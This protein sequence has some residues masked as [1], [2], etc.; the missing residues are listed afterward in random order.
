MMPS[1]PLP[2][3]PSLWVLLATTVVLA[4]GC[5]DPVG[6]NPDGGLPDA[7]LPTEA[8]P[9]AENMARIHFFRMDGDYAGWA[10][11]LWGDDLNLP[12]AVT[13][14]NPWPQ[15]G[16]YLDGC[17]PWAYFDIPIKPGAAGI[18]FILHKGDTKS[19]PEDMTWSFAG[20][21]KEL[22]Q[23][24]GEATLH[25]TRPEVSCKDIGSLATARAHWVDRGR[26][27]WPLPG[28]LA[29][30]SFRLYHSATGAV[31]V[32]A[33]A[34]TISGG[35]RVDLTLTSTPWAASANGSR[36]PHLNGAPVL[37]LP[38]AAL[39]SAPAWLRGQVVVARF[40]AQ[41]ALVDH[42][43]LQV[44]GVLDDLY[45][46][47]AKDAQLGVSWV[48]GSP[49]FRVWA[50]TAQSVAL[51]LYAS[52]TAAE[53]TRHEMVRDDASGIWSYTG[54][55]TDDRKSYQYEVKV[56]AGS[57]RRVETNL[58]TDPYSLSLS[59]DSGRSLVVNLDDADLKPADWDTLVKPE[60]EQP[61]DVSI[62][63]LHVRDFS[64]F[65][66][67]VPPAHRGKFKAFTHTTSAG[68][69]HLKGLADAGLSHLHLLPSFDIATIREDSADRTEPDYD[70][71]MTAVATA[72]ASEVPQNLVTA[73]K[74]ADGFNWGYDP[75]H[76]NAPEGSYSTAPDD[77]A[78]RVLEFREMVQAL[79]GIGLRVVMDV[80]Y[81]HTAASGQSSKSVLDR[82]VPGYYHRLDEQGK[83][84]TSTCC[85]NTATEHAM[86]RKLMGDSLVLWATQYKVDGFRFDL[87]G[88][89]MKA[90]ML[91]VKQR[92]AALTPASG[93]VDGSKIYLY[94]EGWNFGEVENNKRGFNATQ[95]NMKGTGIGTFNDRLRD[96][97]RGGGPFDSGAAL[98][99]KQ[100]FIN[101]LF[102]DP[103]AGAPT[104]DAAKAELLR[105]SDLI[106]VGM[107]GNLAE[108]AF[109][110]RLGNTR[111][112]F[113]LDYNGAPAGYTD[114]PQ[115]A[116]TYVSK[117]D[118]QTL[119]DINAYKMPLATPMSD[120]VR[121]QN[122]G[123]SITVLGQG[124]PFL[125]A[126]VDTLR[127]KSLDR[128]SYNSGDWFNRLDWTYSDNNWAV[129]L[130]VAEKNQENWGVMRP[131][132]TGIPKP[133]PADI[134]RAR[135]HLREV[136]A[137]RKSS[138]LFRLATKLQVQERVRFHNT[139]PSQVP[140]LIVMSIVDGTGAD[141]LELDPAPQTVVVL[142]NATKAQ[143]TFTDTAFATAALTLHPA[144]VTSTDPVV[145]TSTFVPA[146]GTFVIP[147][148]TTA[149]FI[150]QSGLTLNR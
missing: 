138:R 82:V 126:G 67:S 121:A 9:L 44:P 90:D 75:F 23:V 71:M 149:V 97:V 34:E 109:V 4:T 137:V 78:V 2:R 80:V 95:L 36:F 118:N 59:K 139:G 111:R 85:D 96:A 103:N 3:G 81:N 58:V 38:E 77:G 122:L 112:G 40:D 133:A 113:M 50:P 17:G 119:F 135:D 130:P 48:D 30:Q 145:T 52:A 141:D 124:I 60:L 20:T 55:A 73:T 147:A 127:S 47:A 76:F 120:R 26:I 104:G 92:L 91:E 136:L 39:S 12:S 114:D 98:Q 93:G 27:V 37:T 25:T 102:Y 123:M 24:L 70:A 46:A 11:H 72:P 150:G 79:N 132:L 7:G 18:N 87:M 41:G 43:S 74:D 6:S 86:M 13:W 142:V 32:D 64:V 45:A 106:R 49:V 19:V 99:T 68:M 42:T 51:L 53:S 29:G 10:L 33:E 5:T 116:I 65:D 31:S 16:L 61:E 84:A 100:G 107:A 15:T 140:G 129:G 128:D 134:Q 148:R 83:V 144:L 108:Y 143:V 63:E 146:G 22:F 14:T 8:P 21:G 125:D 56:Y 131:L 1:T 105:L 94:G 28:A 110:D 88:H 57:T 101:G 115:E 66:T 117:H 54:A 62:Y 69:T 89:H 35:T